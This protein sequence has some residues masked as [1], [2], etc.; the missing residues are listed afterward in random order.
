[1]NMI[2]HDDN[3]I[4]VDTGL[5][6]MQTTIQNNVACALGESPAI[7]GAK[8]NEM[9]FVVS[10][11][12]RKLPSIETAPH[13]LPQTKWRQPLSYLPTN[14]VATAALVFTTNHVAT[15]ALGCRAERSSAIAV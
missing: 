7:V 5:I 14:H 12:V 9:R 8:C 4:Q 2:G 13:L 11:Q 10:L 1:M 6:V 3:Y 15:A